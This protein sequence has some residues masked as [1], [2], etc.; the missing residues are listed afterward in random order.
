MTF[1]VNPFP[2]SFDINGDPTAQYNAFFGEPN[3]DPKLFPKA[4]FSDADFQNA[5]PTTITLDNRGSY[6]VDVF[7]DG[8]YSLR[9]EDTLGAKYRESPSINA[10][11]AVVVPP[12]GFDLLGD[13]FRLSTGQADLV[14][15][16]ATTNIAE[17]VFSTVGPTGSGST[18]IWTAL[19]QIPIGATAISIGIRITGGA[20]GAATLARVALE[21]RKIGSG[22]PVAVQAFVF[23]IDTSNDSA[24]VLAGFVSD[25]VLLLDSTRSI[26][27]RWTGTN[28]VSETV[29]LEF[30]GFYQ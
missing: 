26:D 13:F 15:F 9:I 19:D 23:E 8:D 21:A 22:N 16:S 1:F 20:I 14:T 24:I 28:S 17:N 10:A 5:L 29:T 11:A 27:I 2:Q 25:Q 18:D 7:L 4:P 12:A 30:Q 6:G 3:Q